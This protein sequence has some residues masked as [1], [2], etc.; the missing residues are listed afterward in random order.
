EW[1]RANMD[2]DHLEMLDHKFGQVSPK[3]SIIQEYL[4]FTIKGNDYWFD[5]SIECF[6]EFGKLVK[7][8]GLIHDVTEL[9]N[10]GQLLEKTK[11][12]SGLGWHE[13]DYRSNTLVGTPMFYRILGYEPDELNTIDQL[14]NIIH[15]DERQRVG[16]VMG[17]DIRDLNFC[18]RIYTKAGELKYVQVLGEIERNEKGEPIKGVASIV[19]IS[20]DK[21]F[22][23]KLN[24]IQNLSK[25]G[26]LE[27]DIQSGQFHGSEQ[28]W[29][30]FGVHDPKELKDI[31]QLDQLIYQDDLNILNQFSNWFEDPECA[32]WNNI[33]YRIMTLEG[34]LKHVLC[35]GQITINYNGLATK[36]LITVQDVTELRGVEDKLMQAQKLS[37]TGWFEYDIQN[38]QRSKYSENWMKMHDYCSHERPTIESY[39]QKLYSRDQ[40]VFEHGIAG[41][42]ESMPLSWERIDYRIKTRSGNK[43]YISNSSQVIYNEGRPIKVFG[44]TTDVTAMRNAQHELSRSEELHRLISETSRDIIVLLK[45]TPG[46]RYVSYIFGSNAAM[47]GYPKG[48]LIGIKATNL[49]HPLDRKKY[50]AAY[51]D[52]LKQPDS[53]LKVEIRIKKYD[54]TYLWTEVIANEIEIHNEKFLRLSVRDISERRAYLDK[55]VRANNELNALITAKGNL[56][57]AFDELGRFERVIGQEELL[58]IPVEEFV[59]QEVEAVWNDENGRHM[60]KVVRDSMNS[61]LSN[62]FNCQHDFGDGFNR[63]Y[64][65]STHPY[66][67]IDNMTKVCVIIE[68]ITERNHFEHE[69]LSTNS[70]LKALIKATENLIFAFDEDGNFERVIGDQSKLHMPIPDFKGLKVEE[71]WNDSNGVE[72]AK[73]VRRSLLLGQEETFVC[74]VETDTSEKEYHKVTTHP[75]YGLENKLKV[76]VVKEDI[77]LQRKYEEELKGMLEKERELSKMRSSFVAMASHQFRTPLTVIKS[78]MELVDAYGIEDP[79]IKR[80][81]GRLKREVDRLVNLMEDILTLGK[82]QS[83]QLKA[84]LKPVDLIELVLDITADVSEEVSDQRELNVRHQGKPVEV[85]GDYHMVRHALLNLVDN[86]FKYSKGQRSPEL[87]INYAENDYVIIQ[88][89]DFGI[90]IPKK[91]QSRIFNDFYRSPN[92]GE[93]QGTGLGM[94]ITKEFLAINNYDLNLES[95]EGMGNTFSICIPKP[96]N[97]VS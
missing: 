92:V 8:L 89:K 82:V 59:G 46:E 35:H 97:K 66:I 47:L 26:W 78:N 3:N 17:S 33:Q 29:S 83:N 75:Y 5:I 52:Y 62:S 4:R 48:E 80:V 43:K 69:I 31:S 9:M 16:E 68:D 1:L 57:F 39:I 90:G 37:N 55:L 19:D 15:P 11:R 61:G 67:S 40:K 24:N 53:M 49:F 44:V 18:H 34:E 91:D 72:M 63:W 30:I 77:T 32:E 20:Q 71:V 56:V 79:I 94:S 54:D 42:L 65:V 81:S 23:Q 2:P 76:C 13:I 86:A 14:I 50:E 88:I 36:T 74:V 28:F 12:I 73:M 58:H 85:I 70:E 60:S 51:M 87:H 6:F 7:T 22:E 95:E 96:E 27:M 64:N 10:S 21:L 84:R 41:F 45:G 25:V 38:P 93:I